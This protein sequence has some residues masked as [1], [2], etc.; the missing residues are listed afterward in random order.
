MPRQRHQRFAA[1]QQRGGQRGWAWLD[2]DRWGNSGPLDGIY[3]CAFQQS[4]STA[5]RANHPNEAYAW[6]HP[7]AARAIAL[8]GLGSVSRRL[9]AVG[10]T[11][12]PHYG[13]LVAVDPRGA[14][15]ASPAA[16]STA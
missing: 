13:W 5:S 4:G 9:G 7:A 12:P 16:A 11:D 2:V 14:R 3:W 15:L 6:S 8:R 1:L 10:E